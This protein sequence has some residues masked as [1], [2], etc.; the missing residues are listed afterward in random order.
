MYQHLIYFFN[1]FKFPIV[2]DTVKLFPINYLR[3]FAFKN[4]RSDIVMFIEG[5]Y[6]VSKDFR[7]KLKKK[8]YISY[9]YLA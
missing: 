4:T 1:F 5:D 3:D 7:S 6:V 9:I 8:M 2:D